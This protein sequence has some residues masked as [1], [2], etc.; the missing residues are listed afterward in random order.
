MRT[1]SALL[2]VWWSITASATWA[3]ALPSPLKTWEASKMYVLKPFEKRGELDQGILRF[4]WYSLLRVAKG[5]T[6]ALALGTRHGSSRR[7]RLT[8][9]STDAR[10]FARGH[11]L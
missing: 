8:P 9:A 2:L 1:W 3:E 7:A 10:W 4:T 11:P 5:Y 6:L